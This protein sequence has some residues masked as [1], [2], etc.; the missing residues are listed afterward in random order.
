MS[1][2]FEQYKLIHKKITGSPLSNILLQIAGDR[3]CLISS[4]LFAFG[5]E[6]EEVEEALREAI[7]NNQLL[8]NQEG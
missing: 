1:E 2:L 8:E 3:Y 4:D 5:G 7:A 6:Y